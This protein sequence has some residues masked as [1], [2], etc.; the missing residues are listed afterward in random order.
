[1]KNIIGAGSNNGG[2]N[3]TSRIEKEITSIAILSRKFYNYTVKGQAMSGWE[4]GGSTRGKIQTSRTYTGTIYGILSVGAEASVKDF[5]KANVSVNVGRSVS[6]SYTNVY[7]FD[8]KPYLT[9]AVFVLH[10][11]KNETG[12]IHIVYDCK[13]YQN[14]QIV[15]TWREDRYKTYD[16]YEPIK[17]FLKV[18]YEPNPTSEYHPIIEDHENAKFRVWRTPWEY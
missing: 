18:L 10:H 14:N 9:G 6:A 3:T 5:L 15:K 2:G 13:E 7:T 8:L 17:T 4:S 16:A 11:Y 1:M 12:E